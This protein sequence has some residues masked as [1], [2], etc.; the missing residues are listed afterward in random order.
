MALHFFQD[1]LE[2]IDDQLCQCI[3]SE[4]ILSRKGFA[5]RTGLPPVDNAGH[6]EK[7]FAAVMGKGHGGDA[8]S[9]PVVKGIANVGEQLHKA[10]LG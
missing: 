9:L 1:A 4:S 5:S 2:S 7:T 3:A 8:A 6:P 10:A